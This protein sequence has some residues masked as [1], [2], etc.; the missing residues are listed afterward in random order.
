MIEVEVKAWNERTVKTF[1]RPYRAFSM[2]ARSILCKIQSEREVLKER[3]DLNLSENEVSAMDITMRIYFLRHYRP[4]LAKA[5]SI[6]NEIKSKKWVLK[7]IMSY[8]NANYVSAM[9]RK[10][11]NDHQYAFTDHFQRKPCQSYV[12]YRAKRT[13]QKAILFKLSKNE[14]SA[15]DRKYRKDLS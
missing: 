3:F 9:A 14:V 11:R 5:R 6:L 10:G 1:H 8:L 13:V 2:A 7:A 12:E 4:F 15:L